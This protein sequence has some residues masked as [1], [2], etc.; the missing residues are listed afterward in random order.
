M[1]AVVA[2]KEVS[3][4]GG[5]RTQDTGTSG[6]RHTSSAVDPQVQSHSRANTVRSCSRPRQNLASVSNLETQKVRLETYSTDGNNKTQES[7]NIG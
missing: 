6:H 3:S 7:Y 1:R 4:S 5:W 2:G